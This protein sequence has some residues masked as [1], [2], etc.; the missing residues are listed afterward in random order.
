MQPG[1]GGQEKTPVAHDTNGAVLG[2][3]TT[4]AKTLAN[5]GVSIWLLEAIGVL[6][7][8]SAVVLARVVRP[9]AKRK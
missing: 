3:T 7:M 4:G 9:A 2:A 8:V 6:V 1:K 5:T